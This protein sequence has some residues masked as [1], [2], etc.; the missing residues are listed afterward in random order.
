MFVVITDIFFDPLFI[1]RESRSTRWWKRPSTSA[2]TFWKLLRTCLPHSPSCSLC[3]SKCT[4]VWTRP[5]WPPTT[6]TSVFASPERCWRIRHLPRLK[7]LAPSPRLALWIPREAV[8]GRAP[9]CFPHLRQ[10]R[11]AWF[12]TLHRIS[13]A[14]IA[15]DI[16]D[17][18]WYLKACTGVSH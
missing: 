10:N 3:I 6:S 11:G 14:L 15:P 5:R 8:A 9:T 16:Y 13:W 2:P 12:Q 1:F 4:P 7:R 17:P 18:P